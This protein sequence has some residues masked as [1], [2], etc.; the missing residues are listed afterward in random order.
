MHPIS[1]FPGKLKHQSYIITVDITTSY[2]QLVY[3]CTC[4]NYFRAP[5]YAL[6]TGR[7]LSH[8]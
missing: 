3:T 7:V 6:H 2:V 5:A 4:S 1:P 8:P